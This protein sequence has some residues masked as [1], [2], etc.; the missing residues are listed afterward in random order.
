MDKKRTL[1]KRELKWE[2]ELK[3]SNNEAL[4]AASDRDILEAKL[5]E[6][7]EERRQRIDV[8]V[9]GVRGNPVNDK[10]A[11][12]VRGLLASGA[13]AAATLKQ[14]SLNARFFLHDEDYSHFVLAL[15]KI[16]WFQFQREG[17]GLESYLYTLTRIAK[18]DRVLQWGFDETS[19]EGV[20]TLNQWVRIKEGDDLHIVTLECAGLLVGSTAS[21]VAECA[22]PM[23]ARA[24]GNCNAA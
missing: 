2:L 11:R 5:A 18:F 12:H 13:S 3:L 23:G 22:A 21:R 17:L 24:R 16:R 9:S 8:R 19:L 4:K 20:A 7:V 15:P 6:L 14:L 1:Q 10:F